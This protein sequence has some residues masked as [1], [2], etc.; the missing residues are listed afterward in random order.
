MSWVSMSWNSARFV[1]RRELCKE[2]GKVI[3][4]SDLKL[5]PLTW[6]MWST[7]EVRR[8][9][10]KSKGLALP[11]GLGSYLFI[12]ERCR[13]Q[14]KALSALLLLLKILTDAELERTAN[15]IKTHLYTVWALLSGIIKDCTYI[16]RFIASHQKGQRYLQS[17]VFCAD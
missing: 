15:K 12:A 13:G 6:S 9:P 3:A 4:I 7:T 14:Q 10:C 16:H 2:N 17:S 11:S 1:E 5:Y 8:S